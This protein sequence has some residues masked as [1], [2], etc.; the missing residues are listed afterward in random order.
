MVRARADG[1]DGVLAAAGRLPAG[2]ALLDLALGRDRAGAP[3]DGG[4]LVAPLVAA[5]WRVLILSASTD[6]VRVGAALACG[7][8]GWLPK[9]APFPSLLRS[10]ADAAHGRDVMAP[11]R[12]QLLI[13]LHRRTLSDRQAR[14]AR[15]DSLTRR[16]REVLVRLAEG[17]RAQ[18]VAAEFVVSLATVRTQ[19]RSI[20]AK[21][22]VSSQLEAVALYRHADR[23]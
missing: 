23:H 5:G 14:Q 19:I 1:S 2:L 16:E 6:H 10:L 7:A 20:L 8:V 9:N 22:G 12:R 18:A 17:H 4:D 11:E 13:D 3:V 21:L 15:I